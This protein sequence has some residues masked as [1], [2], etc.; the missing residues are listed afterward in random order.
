MP[1]VGQLRHHG[2][3]IVLVRVVGFRLINED[4]DVDGDDNDVT[5]EGKDGVGGE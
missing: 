4:V 2:W 3:S 1:A 5:D